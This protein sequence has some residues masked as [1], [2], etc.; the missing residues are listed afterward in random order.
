MSKVLNDLPASARNSITR[1][2]RVLASSNNSQIAEQLGLDPSSFS[3]MKN[4]KKSNGLT[5][6]EN[7]CA[8]LDSLGL[9]LVPKKYKMISE[10]RLAA[11]LEMAK[12]W[13][14]RIDSVDDLF[15][16]EIDELGI[17]QELGYK[18]KA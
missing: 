14:D 15:Q 5:D 7:V 2:L 16:D 1:V 3:R 9:K 8:M 12:S 11:L 13:M 17:G 4:D 18:E 6:I 10:T